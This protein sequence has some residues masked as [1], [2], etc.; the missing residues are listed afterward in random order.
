MPD[1]LQ[2]VPSCIQTASALMFVP[3]LHISFHDIIIAYCILT[4]VPPSRGGGINF[5]FNFVHSAQG[6]K[7][8]LHT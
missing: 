3:Y 1:G 8:P 2:F 6:V 7:K 5:F 4:F